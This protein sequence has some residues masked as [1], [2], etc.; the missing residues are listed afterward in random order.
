MVS[1][2]QCPKTFQ[3]DKHYNIHNI[4]TNQDGQEF[5]LP[6]RPPIQASR[7]IGYRLGLTGQLDTKVDHQFTEG[8]TVTMQAIQGGIL[9]I[10]MIQMYFS[11]MTPERQYALRPHI[12][13]NEQINSIQVKSITL[14]LRSL[15]F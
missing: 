14:L 13:T 5:S 15:N 8:H 1:W 3:A 12:L 10:D 4:T 11:V 6:F 9:R 7:T 2:H